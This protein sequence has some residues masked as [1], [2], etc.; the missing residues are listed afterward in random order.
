MIMRFWMAN[1]AVCCCVSP[2]SWRG[3]DPAA[4]AGAASASCI[5]TFS[6]TFSTAIAAGAAVTI[7]SD[8]YFNDS[9][10]GHFLDDLYHLDVGSLSGF[11]VAAAQAGCQRQHGGEEK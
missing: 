8:D 10:D 5:T 2:M 7:F 6:T 9:F 4:C 3:P 11:L 1:W